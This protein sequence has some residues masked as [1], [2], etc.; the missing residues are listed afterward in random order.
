MSIDSL[1][2]SPITSA[3][4]KLFF[5]PVSSFRFYSINTSFLQNRTRV[6]NASE[7][8]LDA[9]VQTVGTRSSQTE[10]MTVSHSG[11][12]FYS[13]L[14]NHAVDQWNTS[15][16]FSANDQ[17]YKDER[18]QWTAAFGW[19]GGYLYVISNRWHVASNQHSADPAQTEPMYRL[20]RARV[21]MDG[22]MGPYRSGKKVTGAAPPRAGVAAAALLCA[23]L[24][25]VRGAHSN[26]ERDIKKWQ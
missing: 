10:A 26:V 9:E 7:A 12:M 6:L 22:Y 24:V 1:A 15:K 4:Q 5:A 14:N 11:I 23:V 2:I 13:V 16:P 25:A 21:D 17:V 3:E 19:D 20:M 8:E 18:L